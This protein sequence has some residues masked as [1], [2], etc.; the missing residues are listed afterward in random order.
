MY[1]GD[2]FGQIAECR[3]GEII[4]RCTAKTINAISKKTGKCKARLRTKF[5]NG[6]E[7][8]KDPTHAEH[9]HSE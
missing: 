3:N 6:F 7:M 8:I 9:V 4:W 2:Q 1:K 5:I